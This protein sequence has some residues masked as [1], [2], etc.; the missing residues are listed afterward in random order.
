MPT[1]EP[2]YQIKSSG[3]L[4]SSLV[5]SYLSEKSYERPR[6]PWQTNG[7]S[8]PQSF[9]KIANNEWDWFSWDESNSNFLFCAFFP[10]PLLRLSWFWFWSWSGMEWMSGSFAW[11]VYKCANYYVPVIY[12]LQFSSFLAHSLADWINMRNGGYK[13]VCS[14]IVP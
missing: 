11:F 3:L 6:H 14:F 1:A 4:H 9:C 10:V 2:N 8:S 7:K 5:S 12:V 13:S